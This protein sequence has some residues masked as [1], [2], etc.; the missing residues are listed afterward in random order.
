M[1]LE[2]TIRR[3]LREE[4]QGI[5]KFIDTI[6]SKFRL[7]EDLKQFLID[8]INKSNC[9]NIEFSGFKA[10]AFGF[11]LH[12]GV[13][14]NKIILNNQLDFIL[15]V[16]FH[17]VAHQYQF[18]KYGVEKMYEC[19]VGDMSVEDA[20]KFMKKTEEVAD[21]FAARKMRELYKKGLID[22]LYIAPQMYKNMP[23]S[24]LIFM[25]SNYKNQMK[26]KNIT[27]PEKI[28]EFFYNMVKSE[29]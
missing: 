15:F 22:R 4:T 13:L 9:K 19:Y 17:E 24:Q 3:I 12:D 2:E 20:A 26:S 29:L 23:L 27:S 10:P 8:F 28:S 14:I 1:R 11:A 6:D 7:S 25:I 16:I 5:N 21:D 18:K